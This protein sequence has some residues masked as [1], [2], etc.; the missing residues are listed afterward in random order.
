MTSDV[1][2]AQRMRWIDRVLTRTGLGCVVFVVLLV[3]VAERI[4]RWATPFVSAEPRE[5]AK[6]RAMLTRWLPDA[7]LE[8]MPMAMPASA[9]AASMYA[10]F[11]RRSQGS[12]SRILRCELPTT[13]IDQLCRVW[14][15]RTVPN[16]DFLCGMPDWRIEN[17]GDLPADTEVFLVYEAGPDVGTDK[18]YGGIAIQ[19]SEGV[20]VFWVHHHWAQ[21]N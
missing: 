21:F 9:N 1:S 3:F 7:A 8:H 4:E 6:C 10:R 2:P 11:V 15:G 19:R 18:T 13:D 17:F 20:V 16:R 14:A 5:Y 12:Q